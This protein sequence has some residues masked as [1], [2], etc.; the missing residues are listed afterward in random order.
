M[1]LTNSFPLSECKNLSGPYSRRI[2]PS[3]EAI[4]AASFDRNGESQHYQL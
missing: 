1:Q 3:I 4:P 2:F